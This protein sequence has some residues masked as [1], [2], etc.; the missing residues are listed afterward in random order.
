MILQSTMHLWKT[1]CQNESR[2]LQTMKQTLLA[3]VLCTQTQCQQARWMR[4]LCTGKCRGL[5]CLW[6]LHAATCSTRAGTLG[7]GRKGTK[8]RWETAREGC[9]EGGRN[10]KINPRTS[11]IGALGELAS[12]RG[13][14]VMEGGLQ[15]FFLVTDLICSLK[16]G[17][18]FSE[19]RKVQWSCLFL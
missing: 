1:N 17:C 10:L 8:V 7:L 19:G 5:C 4:A 13:M 3:S 11:D 14:K 2:G 16:G 15:V 6:A 9:F 18:L 12:K